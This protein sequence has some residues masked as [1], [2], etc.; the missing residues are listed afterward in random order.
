[1]LSAFNCKADPTRSFL[2]KVAGPSNA[3]RCAHRAP[4]HVADLILC[5]I[6]TR[7]MK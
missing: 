7:L 6:R 5:D 1:L 4:D 2:D 3:N